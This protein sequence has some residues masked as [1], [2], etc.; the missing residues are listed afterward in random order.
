MKKT[1]ATLWQAYTL[2]A[3]LHWRG[4]K[5][6]DHVVGIMAS[7]LLSLGK[8]YPVENITGPV[9]QALVAQWKQKGLSGSTVNRKL[10][11]LGKVLRTAHQ[12][13]MR[14]SPP[15][16]GLRLREGKGRRRIVTLEEVDLMT[17]DMRNR[18]LQETPALVEFLYHT[19]MRVGE[20]LALKEGDVHLGDVLTS[21][22]ALVRDSKSGEPRT[23][24]LTRPAVE[25]VR[26][27]V[28]RSA[29]AVFNLTGTPDSQGY[30]NVEWNRSKFNVGLHTDAEFVPHA[31]RHTCA[32][33]LVKAGVPISVVQKWLGHKSV[34]TTQRYAHVNDQQLKDAAK[35]LEGMQQR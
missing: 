14:S 30:F 32:T 4:T 23:V 13:G 16:T 17:A 31:L 33:N 26:P 25:A 5:N 27:F 1:K 2:T 8:D 7:I 6:E 3:S 22:Y 15:P 11:A 24:P 28:G 18:G 9:V 35:A 21:P 20:A 10:A 34:T 29:W 12:A 19:G